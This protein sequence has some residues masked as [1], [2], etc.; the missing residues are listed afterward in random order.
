MKTT[1]VEKIREFIRKNT[2]TRKAL[3]EFIICE[4]GGVSKETYEYKNHHGHYSTNITSWRYLGTIEYKDRKIHLTPLGK[5]AKSLYTLSPKDEIKQLKKRLEDSR[6]LT[7]SRYYKIYNLER[8]L[9]EA[10]ETIS[11]HEQTISNLRHQLQKSQSK[12][13]ELHAYNSVLEDE[14]NADA[15][16]Q[17]YNELKEFELQWHGLGDNA[18][19]KVI[20]KKGGDITL[21]IKV[22]VE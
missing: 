5:R 8:E 3:V 11:E 2:P 9:R 19:K 18:S 16:Q 10:K 21:H 4:L 12:A 15:V 14:L 20:S 6:R 1:K 13:T 22:S 17:K 7:S